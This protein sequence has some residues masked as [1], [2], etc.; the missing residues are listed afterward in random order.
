MKG[1]HLSRTGAV[2]QQRRYQC[3]ISLQYLTVICGI[4][5]F[6]T[7]KWADLIRSSCVENEVPK[8]KGNLLGIGMFPFKDCYRK[9]YEMVARVL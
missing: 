9:S 8:F 3:R 5:E 7:S 2:S 4:V 1:P 6:S